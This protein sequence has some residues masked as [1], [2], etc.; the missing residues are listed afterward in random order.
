MFCYITYEGLDN[1]YKILLESIY[2]RKFIGILRRT[3][4]KKSRTYRENQKEKSIMKSLS[5]Y[6]LYLKM[7]IIPYI[8]P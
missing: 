2:H 4:K 8:H 5:H 1:T 6:T 7:T 3:V